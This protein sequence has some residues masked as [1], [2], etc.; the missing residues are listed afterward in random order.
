MATEKLTLICPIRGILKATK[1]SKDGLN[2]TEEYARVEAIKYL[3]KQGY[4]K[5]N[6]KI[7][8]V[9]KKFGNSGR[10]S[11]RADFIV[12]DSPVSTI[13]DTIDEL[14][15]HAVLLCEVK[16]NNHNY[17]YVKNTQ[18][19]PMLD[20]ASQQKAVGLYWD[21]IEQRIFWQEWIE[22]NKEY[23]EG[24][25]SLVPKFG[26]KINVKPLT[27]G[28][29]KPSDS[30]IEVFGRIEDILHKAS[31]DPEQRYEVILQLILAKLFD[32]HG[33][34]GNLSP[35]DIQDFTLLGYKEEVALDK[36]NLVLARAVTYYEKHLP[37]KINDNLNVKPSVL[38]D[39]LKI[40][41][42]IKLTASKRNVVQTFYM[43]F[44]KD[45]YRWDLAQF[46]TPT[47]VTDFII[48]VLNP[49]FGEHIKDPAC[50]SADFLTAAFHRGRK[51]DP[52]YA[53]SIWGADNSLNAVQVSILNMLLNG[54]G[55]TH[56][57]H[58]DSLETVNKYKDKFDI[59]VCNP[60][61]GTRIIEK[62]KSILSLFDLGHEWVLDP[63][64]NQLKKSDT[65][66][67]SQEAGMLFVEVC[68]KQ[69]KPGGRIAII[70][71]NGYLGNRSLKY[72]VLREFMLRHC[73]IVSICSFPRFTFKTSGADVSASVVFLEKRTSPL[74]NSR[75]DD[76]Y[77]FNVEMIQNVGWEVGNK[78]A[79][80]VYKRNEEDGSFI[81]NNE[82]E[83][84]IDADF[85][86]AIDDLRNS[87]VSLQSPWLLTSD[88]HTGEGWSVSIKDV[89][90]DQS[91]TF[92]PKRYCSKIYTLRKEICSSEYLKLGEIVE[93][94]P[95]LK[96]SKG[97]SISI[98]SRKKYKYIE[99]QDIGYGE[100]RGTEYR[101]WELPDR[102]KH[103]AEP[104]DLYIGSIW[105]SVSKWCLVG[106]EADNYVVT[107]G[108]YR[109][110]VLPQ[111]KEY[112]L[113]LIVALSTELYA[114]QMRAFARGSDGLAE[115][116]EV[117]LK[118][119]LIPI[120]SDSTRRK[121]IQPFVDNLLRGKQSLKS[122]IETMVD[123]NELDVP[124]PPKR[125]NHTVLV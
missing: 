102:A 59:L 108:C 91:L 124:V 56:I 94:I 104:G 6:F 62:R 60:P 49:Q 118:E 109:L 113:D 116:A 101:G 88:T 73:K 47:T 69:T 51:F 45:L 8:A 54:D 1:K 93:V 95:Q 34:Y 27:L 55:K 16:K 24:P 36:F 33:H 105:G 125:P 19:K 99:I 96:N 29:T 44:A 11:F 85:D 98:D 39:I 121:Q 25:L 10:N 110:R 48:D 90:K 86:F 13:T 15:K 31:I 117:D 57:L 12:L 107:N 38:T 106:P 30:L 112:L 64:N 79:E 42:P 92:D 100:Y 114:T 89:L 72:H 14:L 122:M 22:G 17:D 81:I 61:F 75:N 74:M 18:V 70:L 40:L 35:L 119:V 52:N 97:N 2:P 20:F 120:I 78:R 80:P 5:E 7:E 32:E 115:V 87:S 26:S 9:I 84:I 63:S 21:N 28:D 43:K 65:T 82:G 23:R 77:E 53:D 111:M 67:S 68:I 71:P 83:R 123:N 103:F 66:S 41:A 3:I 58:E 46:F 76:D 50:G 4:P 37:K